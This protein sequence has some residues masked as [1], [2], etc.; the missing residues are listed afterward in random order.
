[1]GR[2]LPQSE[3]L[4]RQYSSVNRFHKLNKGEK[5]RLLLIE[6]GPAKEGEPW[7]AWHEWRH[8]LQ[9]PEVK[10][11]GVVVREREW[12]GTYRCLGRPDELEAHRRDPEK[13]P[14]CAYAAESDEFAPRPYYA[15]NVIRYSTKPGSFELQTPF[16]AQSLV[17]VFTEN[18]YSQIIE[19]MQMY[20][21]GDG[22]VDLRRHDMFV[23]CENA[24]FQ[25]YELDL[26]PAAAWLS[27]EYN[28][29]GDG[30]KLKELVAEVF[31]ANKCD[32]E[33]LA[34]Q[35]AFKVSPATLSDKADQLAALLGLASTPSSMNSAAS[36]APR[37]SPEELAAQIGSAPA[38]S[39]PLDD[40][41]DEPSTEMS[42][43][44][45]I[46][47]SG[48]DV[49]PPSEVAFDDDALDAILSD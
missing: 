19:K 36:S 7:G 21:T 31:K 49:S 18:V 26:A 44:D 10:E 9:M 29:S 23:T 34:D 17:W 22:P 8:N 35:I 5:A 37:L 20:A 33:T 13:C 6:L 2:V 4:T 24:T 30:V 41:A 46:E 47:E 45:I 1:M 3:S 39:L 32:D 25:N 42:L 43:N 11:N 40:E 12:V 15:M 27:K 48:G 38:P 16:S 14:A 28:K